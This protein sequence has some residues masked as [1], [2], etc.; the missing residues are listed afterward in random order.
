[1]SATLYVLVVVQGTSG[2]TFSPGHQGRVSSAIQGACCW[3][4]RL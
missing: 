3:L 2:L 4:F 1:M